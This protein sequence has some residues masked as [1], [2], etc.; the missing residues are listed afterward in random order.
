MKK[1]KYYIPLGNNKTLRITLISLKGLKR[2]GEIIIANTN[3]ILANMESESKR[4]KEGKE[5][6]PFV[7]EVGKEKFEEFEREIRSKKPSHVFYRKV[8]DIIIES[9]KPPIAQIKQKDE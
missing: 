2:I 8:F 4:V 9:N 5:Y 6:K 3:N 1:I 7:I